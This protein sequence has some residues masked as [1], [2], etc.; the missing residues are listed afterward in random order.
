MK[1][2]KPSGNVFVWPIDYVTEFF[3]GE[4]GKFYYKIPRAAKGDGERIEAAE[5]GYGDLPLT[6]ID[7]DPVFL[8][9]RD[10]P[11]IKNKLGTLDDMRETLNLLVEVVALDYR[12]L[13]A[14]RINNINYVCKQSSE[15]FDANAALAEIKRLRQRVTE[16]EGQLADSAVQA[17]RA[18]DDLAV[19][20]GGLPQSRVN[21]AVEPTKRGRGRPRKS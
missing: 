5:K 11:Y 1:I 6:R 7:H 4:K 12:Q 18:N 8:F 3:E 10:F 21:Q 14:K 9:L 13:L 20:I 15:L 16:L 2:V 17:T 19:T